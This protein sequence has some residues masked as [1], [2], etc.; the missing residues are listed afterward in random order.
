MTDDYQAEVKPQDNSELKLDEALEELVVKTAN[1]YGG[2][3][4]FDNESREDMQLSKNKILA[5]HTAEREKLL[6]DLE[7]IIKR[8]TVSGILP[9]TNSDATLHDL[10]EFVASQRRKTE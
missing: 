3:E 5:W 4:G 9:M 2:F 8:N 6:D 7:M 1:Q 10:L